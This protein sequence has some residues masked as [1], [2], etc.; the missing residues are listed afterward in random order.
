MKPEAELLADF[1]LKNFHER[2]LR[3]IPLTIPPLSGDMSQRDWVA[4]MEIIIGKL[5][6]I[7]FERNAR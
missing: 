7:R 4:G 3:D 2:T 6:E 5:D 1:Y